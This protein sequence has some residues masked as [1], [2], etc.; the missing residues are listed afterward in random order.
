MGALRR[1]DPRPDLGPVP[2]FT[3]AALT[4]AFQN[5]TDRI[6][7]TFDQ[8]I[9]WAITATSANT[10]VVEAHISIGSSASIIQIA[11]MEVVDDFGIQLVFPGDI[12]PIY[13]HVSLTVPLCVNGPGQIY[14]VGTWTLPYMPFT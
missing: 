3:L 2:G 6:V 13:D 8:R 14:V 12:N 7:V 5:D 1:R 9:A 11:G 4:G 10:G